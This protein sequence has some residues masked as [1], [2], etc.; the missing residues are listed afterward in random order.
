[1][2]APTSHLTLEQHL[3][4]F[5]PSCTRFAE[6]AAQAVTLADAGKWLST[7][8]VFGNAV[9]VSVIVEQLR[10]DPFLDQSDPWAPVLSE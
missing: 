8:N 10:L 9:A 1:M 2:S 3:A 5:T 7:L 6:V 4:S